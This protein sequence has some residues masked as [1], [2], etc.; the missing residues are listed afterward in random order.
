MR[1]K[2]QPPWRNLYRLLPTSPAQ[3]GWTSW[4]PTAALAPVF[5]ARQQLHFSGTADCYGSC[6]QR[7]APVRAGAAYQFLARGRF[8]DVCSPE[9]SIF[10]RLHWRDEQD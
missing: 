4:S 1:I 2:K 9:R 5:S 8:T 3:P 7:I 6:R 10:A